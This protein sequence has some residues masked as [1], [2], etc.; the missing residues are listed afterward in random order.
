MTREVDCYVHHAEVMCHVESMGGEIE[1]YLVHLGD[2][3]RKEIA[4]DDVIVEAIDRQLTSEAEKTEDDSETWEPFAVIWKSDLVT[5]AIEKKFKC[6]MKQVKINS[7][8]HGPRIKFEKEATKVEMN[9]TYK[10]KAFKSL[11]KGGKKPKDHVM[12][13]IHLVYDVKQDGRHKARLVAG[14][15]IA[16]PNTDIYYSS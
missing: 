3:K 11:G 14:G 15:H 10:Y 4:T 16:G 2:R 6:Q 1:Q 9:K 8:R 13:H 12:I 5:L 7:M